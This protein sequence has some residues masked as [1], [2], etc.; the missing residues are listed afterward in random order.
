VIDLRSG[1]SMPFAS[2][3]SLASQIPI[4]FEGEIDEKE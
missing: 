2:A 1:D 3:T 4:S